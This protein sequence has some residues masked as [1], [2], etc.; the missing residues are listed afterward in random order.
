M[1]LTIKSHEYF[2][3]INWNKYLKKEIKPPFV[4]ELKDDIDLK[5]FDK[6]LLKHLLIVIDLHYI[7]DQ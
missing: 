1:N 6:N 2:K 5:H 7:Q 4:P 3:E